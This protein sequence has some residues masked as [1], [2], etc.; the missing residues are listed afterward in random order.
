MSPIDHL[1]GYFAH[2]GPIKGLLSDVGRVDCNEDVRQEA[3]SKEIAVD[4]QIFAT[5][6]YSDARRDKRDDD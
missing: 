3:A 4:V 6:S 1:A 5:K 2:S